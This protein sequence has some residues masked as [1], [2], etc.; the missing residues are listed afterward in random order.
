MGVLNM[1]RD[2]KKV[3]PNDTVMVPTTLKDSNGNLIKV[4]RGFKIA[5]DS[6]INVTEGIVSDGLDGLNTTRLNNKYRCM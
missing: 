5:P 6:G 3:H 1:A 4:P 2:I